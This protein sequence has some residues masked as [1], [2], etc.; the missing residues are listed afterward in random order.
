MKLEP[1]DTQ[2]RPFKRDHSNSAGVPKVEGLATILVLLL[3]VVCLVQL[4][5]NRLGDPLGDQ[6]K[7]LQAAARVANGD[8]LY[9]D[10][11][12][13]YGPLPIYVLALLFRT[14]GLDILTIMGLSVALVSVGSLLLY[15]TLRSSF[16]PWSSLALASLVLFLGVFTWLW[17]ASG[18]AS[19]GMVSALGT[20][21]GLTWFHRTDKRRWLLVAGC[22]TGFA[23]LCKVELALGCLGAGFVSISFSLRSTNRTGTLADAAGIILVYFTPVVVITAVS[24]GLIMI[25]ATPGKVFAGISGYHL[26]P[27]FN[28]WWDWLGTPRSWLTIAVASIANLFLLALYTLAICPERT[29]VRGKL[30]EYLMVFLLMAIG[31]IVIV[32]VLLPH[33]VQIPTSHTSSIAQVISRI[34]QQLG[35]SLRSPQYLFGLL[36][37]PSSIVLTAVFG[38]LLFRHFSLRQESRSNINHG[39]LITLAA[40]GILVSIRFYFAGSYVPAYPALLP[41][42]FLI[43]AEA[44]P[45]YLSKRFRTTVS[46]RRV[47]IVLGI[48]FILF[49]SALFVSS[50]RAYQANQTPIRTA[51]GAIRMGSAYATELNN[52]LTRIS[53]QTAPGESTFVAGFAAGLYFLSDRRSPTVSDVL[54]PGVLD[55]KAEAGSVI[56]AIRT[57]QPGL[58]IVPTSL[59][60]L[61]EKQTP[62]PNESR[63]S[64]AYDYYFRTYQGLWDLV[65]RCYSLLDKHSYLSVYGLESPSCLGNQP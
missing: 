58:I 39:I 22:F 52:V 7:Y 24:Y 23:L 20:L 12:W 40:Y 19:F 1:L 38:Y 60:N 3:M 14:F 33:L 45:T 62:I 43:L 34:G 42:V 10:V 53:E 56:Q 29:M 28:R 59:V 13:P 48:I 9:R 25:A 65:D 5:W 11:Q 15:A 32:G 27:T 8:L 35:R 61:H 41:V 4:H 55:S 46:S 51:H 49:L 16:S 50:L 2:R 6:G 47:S 21:L 64:I 44:I 54:K 57:A 31:L 36:S 30:K 17:G 18:S 37:S 63:Q 26:I